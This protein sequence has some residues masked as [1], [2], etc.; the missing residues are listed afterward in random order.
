MHDFSQWLQ[1]AGE[2]DEKV[3]VF[4]AFGALSAR[5]PLL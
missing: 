1:S 3:C 4:L 2:M 5:S